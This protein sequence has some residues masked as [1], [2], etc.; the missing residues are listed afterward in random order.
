MTTVLPFVLALVAVLGLAVGSFLN[1]VVHR[2]PAGMSVSHPASACPRCDHRIRGVDNIPVV[3]WLVLRGRCRDCAAPISIRYPS[4]EAATCLLAVLVTAFLATAPWSPLADADA[5]ADSRAR[6]IVRGALI[7]VALLYLMAISVA[8]T[9]I[10]L[11]TR[12]LPNRI[13]L[14]AAVVLPVLLG[15]AAAV[16]GDWGAI[17]RGF[18]GFVGLGAVY[19]C[20]ALAVP[21]G[22]GF[23][24]VKLAAPLGFV[25]AYLGWGPLAVGSFGAFLLGGTFAIVLVLVRRAGRGSGI[26]FGPWMLGGA[27]IGIVLGE[28]LWRG[29]LGILGLA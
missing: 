13:V 10:D 17:V 5:A 7:L 22:M 21:G 18:V 8:L 20:L 27:W 25:L 3:S 15:I 12:T 11:D 1:V 26:P 29:Y 16:T 19:L 6:S 2:V 24:D 23:G 28:P 4:V 9:L 14:P